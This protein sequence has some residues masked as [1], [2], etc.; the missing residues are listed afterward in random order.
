M[1]VNNEFSKF[2]EY[3]VL[4]DQDWLDQ[5]IDRRGT[6]STKWEKYKDT[7]ILPFWV[8]DMDFETPAFILDAVKERLCHPILGYSEDPE[9]LSEALR[10]WLLKS[11]DWSIR[12]EWVVWLPG[13]VSGLNVACRMIDSNEKVMVPTPSYHPF[14][15]LAKNSDKQEIRVPLKLVGGRWEMDFSLMREHLD[16]TGVLAISNPQNPTGRAYT[17]GE[18]GKLSS[19][20]LE[21][22]LLVLSDEIHCPLIID[23]TKNHTPLAKLNESLLSRTITFYG[24]T[25]AYNMPGLGC[26]AAV[27]PDDSVRERFQKASSG[28]LPSIGPL[29]YAAT[30]A[31]LRDTSSWIDT[32][33]RRLRQNYEDLK[34]VTGDRITNVEATYL[35]WIYVGDLKQR[36]PRAYFEQYGLG[37]S[38]GE[39]FG[40]PDYVRF[41]FAAPGETLNEGL[42]RL[43]RALQDI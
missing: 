23:E 20:L 3:K 11:Y 26:A 37:L 4:R 21:K 10:T 9:S 17:E 8:A 30:E 29:N 6:H 1:A 5:L 39:Q 36:D 38:W 19:L 42:E 7:D 16:Q 24:A 27:I 43:N 22:D 18:L 35:A 13:V 14:L 34:Q 2:S 40:D 41:N 25:K 33:N 31:A 15:E 32:L 12:S 28:L